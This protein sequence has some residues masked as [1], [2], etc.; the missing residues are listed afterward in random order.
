MCGTKMG[1]SG[2]LRGATGERAWDLH[3]ERVEE[4][5]AGTNSGQRQK[6]KAHV[7]YICAPFG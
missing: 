6:V 1:T 2:A 4:G 7:L 5:T 3:E